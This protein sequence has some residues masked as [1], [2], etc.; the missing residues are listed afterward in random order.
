MKRRAAFYIWL[1]LFPGMLNAAVPE[2]KPDSPPD[3]R[4]LETKFET[5]FSKFLRRKLTIGKVTWRIFPIRFTAKDITLWEDS[6]LMLAQGPL[7]TMTVSLKTLTSWRLRIS[8]MRFINP[9]GYLRFAHD[10]TSNLTSMIKDLGEFARKDYKHGERQKVAYGVFRIENANVEVIDRDLNIQPFGAPFRVDARGDIHGLGPDTKFPFHLKALLLS[11]ATPMQVTGTGTMS[12]WPQ[13]RLVAEKIPLSAVTPY[14][15]V[16]RW[17]SGNLSATLDF[18][19][20][21]QYV[22]WKLQTLSTAITPNIELPFPVIQVKG[23]FHAYARSHL[24]VTLT[25]KPTRVD[26]AMKIHDFKSKKVSLSVQS[27]GADIDECIQWCR[28]GYWLNQAPASSMNL[29][30]Q[31]RWPVI[32]K[33]TGAANIDAKLDSVMGPQLVQDADGQIN[34]HIKNGRLSGMP[35]LIKAFALLNLS[36]MLGDPNQPPHG[37]W[38]GSVNADVT[39]QRGIARAATP[40]VVES[41]RINLGVVGEIDFP[42]QTIDAKMLIGVASVED[43]VVAHIPF[44]R[45]FR[46]GDKKG[47]IP[48]W[49]SIHGPLNNPDIKLLPLKTFNR[50]FWKKLPGPFQLPEK[51][52]N[53]IYG[54]DQ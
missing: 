2:P 28:T 23:F 16:V 52:L 14:L 8:E 42:N 32:W 1:A 31:S 9:H 20:A 7:A 44:V 18:S 49:L 43:A 36:S 17:F 51:V 33:I 3:N 26:V 35:G 29:P 53:T 11:T 41:P 4:K 30:P 40:I 45:R 15:P 19:K 5:I 21:G 46:S 38:F 22:F 6:K 54:K 27:Q 34:I 50:D 48:I 25:G 13:I 12:N 24:N 10:G 37:L 39:I 47:V